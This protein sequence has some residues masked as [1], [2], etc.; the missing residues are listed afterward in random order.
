MPV[1]DAS[2]AP[3][4][5]EPAHMVHDDGVAIWFIEPLG[6]AIQVRAT[7]PHC[8]GAA[9]TWVSGPAY[10]R[11]LRIRG[12]RAAKL[13]FLHDYSRIRTYDTHARVA[14]TDWGLR[15]RKDVLKIVMAAPDDAP[16]SRMAISVAAAALTV[17]GVPTQ[18][19]S[20]LNVTLKA[21]GYRV[22]LDPTP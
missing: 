19:V 22:M 20:D 4:F 14:L 15:I 5:R 7:P 16:L 3:L 10:A 18:V 1:L 8:T 13:H 11:L 12:A 9:A 2:I 6:M 17:A 21:G